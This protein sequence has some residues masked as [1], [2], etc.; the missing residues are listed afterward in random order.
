MENEFFSR[1]FYLFFKKKIP[2]MH[3]EKNFNSFYLFYARTQSH[4]L[5]DVAFFF[6]TASI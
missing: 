6:I 5:L 1:N 2:R 4:K 3:S